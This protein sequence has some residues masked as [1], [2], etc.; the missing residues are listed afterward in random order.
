MPERQK[1]LIVDDREENL[2]ALEKVLHETGAEIIKA[3]SGDEALAAALH[4]DFALAILD[5]IMPGMSGFELAR[6]LRRDEKTLSLPIIFL[7]ASFEDEE[8]V[9]KGYEAGAVDYIIKPFNPVILNGKTRAFLE[10]GRYRKQLEDMVQERTQ[11]LQHINKILSKVRSVNQLIVRE[12]DEG[13]LIREACKLLVEARGFDGAWIALIDGSENLVDIAHDGFG[14]GS[15]F[16]TDCLRSGSVPLC[17]KEVR[18]QSGVIL[19]HDLEASC[20]ECPLRSDCGDSRAMVTVLEYQG[21]F[22]GFMGIA[23]PAAMT[24]D[25]E[26]KSL[27]Q[28]VAGDIAFALQSIQ[29]GKERQAA[30]E[31]LRESEE[32]YR[33]LVENANEGLLVAQDGVIRFLNPRNSGNTWL[34]SGRIDLQA[35]YRIHSPG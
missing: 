26:E 22:R 21:S 19:T 27:F 33:V 11:R 23:V 17:W 8:H 35:V 4:H 30:V 10:L 18:R 16:F 14:D 15:A 2:F 32:K 13:Q 6:H 9:F 31:D 28:E 3:T 7:T 20:R 5:V 29:D 24:T 25:E 1:I 34:Q 12:K